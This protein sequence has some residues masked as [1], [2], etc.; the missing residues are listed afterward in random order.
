MPPCQN[1]HP[2]DLPEG[3]LFLQQCPPL[4]PK[5]PSWWRQEPPEGHVS[6]PGLQHPCPR[7]LAREQAA[8]WH[9]LTA[10][11]DVCSSRNYVQ[12]SE[13]LI[14]SL[15]EYFLVQEEQGS[16]KSSVDLEEDHN[17][18]HLLEACSVA[19]RYKQQEAE[20]NKCY[21][22]INESGKVAG[23]VGG[24]SAAKGKGNRLWGRQ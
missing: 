14:T 5:P 24:G 8:G 10:C 19:A 15:G 18:N 16:P 21:F 1:T 3:V 20:E 2:P 9:A 6:K 11:N 4:G 7:L 23:A 22:A 17:L 12:N 13:Y